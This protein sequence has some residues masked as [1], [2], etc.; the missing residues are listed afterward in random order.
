MGKVESLGKGVAIWTS[1]EEKLR[2][3]MSEFKTQHRFTWWFRPSYWNIERK[4]FKVFNQ[5]INYRIK[6]ATA[7]KE[8]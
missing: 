6:Y 1:L 8:R 5:L 2:L 4:H 3:E 7:V